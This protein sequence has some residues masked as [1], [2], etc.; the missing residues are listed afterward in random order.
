MHGGLALRRGLLFVGRHARTA[1]VRAYDLDGRAVLRGFTFRDPRLDRSQAGGLDVDDDGRIWVADTPVSRLR[2][3]TAFGQE[4]AGLGLSSERS[5]DDF[6]ER[7]APGLVRRPVDVLVQGDADELQLVVASEGLRRHAV[8]VF[9]ES[10]VL[11]VSLRPLGD[12]RERFR[13]ITRLARRGRFLFVVEREAARIQVFRDFEFHFALRLEREEAQPVALRPLADGRLV[14]GCAGAAP[15]IHVCDRSGRMLQTLATGGTAE[16]S[17]HELQDLAVEEGPS[18]RESRVFALDAD[19]DRIQVFT[20]E[21]RCYG[22][23]EALG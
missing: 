15:G 6:D 21:G 5:L 3:F 10:S 1:S 11:L 19:G 20:L 16:G 9:D 18:E 14:V 4:V 17:I 12:P 13:D 22:A 8:Q 2:C 7:D 23:F